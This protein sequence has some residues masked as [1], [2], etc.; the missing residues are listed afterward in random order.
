MSE[1]TIEV[2][3]GPAFFTGIIAGATALVIGW[4]AYLLFNE[5]NRPS[6]TGGLV[7]TVAAVAA[8]AVVDQIPSGAVLGIAFLAVA[9][10]L[11]LPSIFSPLLALP[12]A[13]LLAF[14]GG[15]TSADW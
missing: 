4:L 2:L 5:G 7:L 14:D 13:M 8:I 10:W 12:G 1:A 15:I 9:G 6:R 3:T 11:P